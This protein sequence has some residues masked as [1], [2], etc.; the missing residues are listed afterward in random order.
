MPHHVSF[1]N[2]YHCTIFRNGF[3]RSV[4]TLSGEG[5]QDDVYSNTPSSLKNTFFKTSVPRV[6]NVLPGE[7]VLLDE[8]F[9][10]QLT[11]DSRKDLISQS[12]NSAIAVMYYRLTSAPTI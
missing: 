5:V 2:V 9:S 12:V 6:K 11:P 3:P 1:P 10:L 7:V 8:V 4:K